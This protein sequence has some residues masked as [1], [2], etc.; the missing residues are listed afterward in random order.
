MIRWHQTNRVPVSADDAFDVIGTNVTVNHPKWESEVQSVRKLTPGPVGAGTRAVVVRK[1]MGRVRESEYEVTEFVPGHSIAF[2]HPQSALDFALRFELTPISSTA[3]E[4]TVD[5]VAQPRG[6]LRIAEP[7]MCLALPRRSR[8]IAD[9][10]I[11][12]I[13]KTPRVSRD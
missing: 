2:R 7:L 13:E 12:V 11:A 1:E 6:A 8:R 9:A 5:V 10:M 3:C 4:I